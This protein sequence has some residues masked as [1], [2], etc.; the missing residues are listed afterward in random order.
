MTKEVSIADIEKIVNFLEAYAEDMRNS[1]RP[2]DT[3]KA[4]AI[5]DVVGRLKTL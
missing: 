1:G 3:Y 4:D 5:E 2:I